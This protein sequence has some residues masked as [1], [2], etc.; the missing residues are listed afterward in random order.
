MVKNLPQKLSDLGE[1]WIKL[2]VISTEIC[3]LM[4]WEGLGPWYL[5]SK[6]ENPDKTRPYKSSSPVQATL[7]NPDVCN[8]DFRQNQTDWKVPLLSYTYSSY[9]HNPDFA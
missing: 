1:V 3:M 6:S 4:F 8:P 7:F 2:Y 9:T 5:Y